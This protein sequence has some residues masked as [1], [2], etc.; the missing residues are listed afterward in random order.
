MRSPNGGRA[1]ATSRERIVESNRFIQER[2]LEAI[3]V[4]KAEK[5]I[6]S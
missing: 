5:D 6:A 2:T 1:V 3:I 4:A